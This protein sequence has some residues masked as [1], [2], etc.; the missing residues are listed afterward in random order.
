M[1]DIKKIKVSE[2]KYRERKP[3]ELPTRKNAI[4]LFCLECCGWQ[5]SETAKC[6]H[7]SCWLY[8]YR[9]GSVNKKEVE[10]EKCQKKKKK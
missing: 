10:E 9:M 5:Y 8:P 3:G 7:E 1:S 4:R 6:S 2:G